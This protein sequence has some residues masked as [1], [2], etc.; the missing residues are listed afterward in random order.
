MLAERLCD[1][2]GVNTVA[3][4]VVDDAEQRLIPRHVSGAHAQH[5]KQLSIPVGDRLSGWVAAVEQPMINADA[6]LNLFD[7]DAPALR[8]ALA[9]SCEGPDEARTVVTLF[10]DPHR[11]VLCSSSTAGRR[12]RCDA[13]STS[14]GTGRGA[15]ALSSHTA[16]PLSA[17]NAHRASRNAINGNGEPEAACSVDRS[18]ALISPYTSADARP[19]NQVVAKNDSAGRH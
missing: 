4:F 14:N 10:L 12:R 15:P 8:S 2:P 13:V 5:V 19:K 6:T 11:S 7:A 16:A 9:I 18:G 3:V 17:E 1:L